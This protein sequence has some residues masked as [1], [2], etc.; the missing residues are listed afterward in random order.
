MNTTSTRTL[1]PIIRDRAGAVQPIPAAIAAITGQPLTEVGRML[2]QCTDALKGLAGIHAEVSPEDA[3]HAA[4]HR[5]GYEPHRLYA[6]QWRRPFMGELLRAYAGSPGPCERLLVICESGDAFAFS[7]NAASAWT[8]SAPTTLTALVQAGTLELD[9]PVRFA[10][11]VRAHRSVPIASPDH[12][13]LES[14]ASQA[15]ALAAAYH[16]EVLPVGWPYWNL[17]FPRG[18]TDGGPGSAATLVCGEHELLSVINERVRQF[19]QA[20]ETTEQLVAR[21]RRG[22]AAASSDS[23]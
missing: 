13:F 16:I 7:G 14:M 21:L 17:S 23:A 4:L 18:M 19:Q 11:T 3:C 8:G 15:F 1:R 22:R 20:D 10:F 9:M 5:F 12:K 6:G 2:L